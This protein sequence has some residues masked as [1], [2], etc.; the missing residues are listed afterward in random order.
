M[1]SHLCGPQRISL[2]LMMIEL[3]GSFGGLF[4]YARARRNAKKI[5]TLFGRMV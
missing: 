5:E 3:V 4:V 2:D 1:V